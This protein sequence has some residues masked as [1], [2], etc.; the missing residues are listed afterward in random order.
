MTSGEWL[1]REALITVK[2]YPTPSAKYHETVCIAGITK[3]EGWIRLY[4]VQFRSL[5]YAQ[6]FEKYQ[7]IHFRMKK[8]ET[9]RRPESF[10][11]DVNSIRVTGHIDTTKD[12]EWNRRREWISPTLN[13]GMCEILKE[14]ESSKKSLGVFR[15]REVTDFLIVDAD[16]EWPGKKQ[17]FMNQLMLFDPPTSKLEK[18]P[19]SFK[20]KYFC[21]DE[22]CRGH[23]QSIIDWEIYELYRNVRKKTEAVEDIKQKIRDKYLAKLCASDRDTMFFVGNHSRWPASFMILGVF[24]PKKRAP[25]LFD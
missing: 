16:A 7:L 21:C 17:A 8:H 9:D 24:W 14:Q 15:P 6:Q 20:Y 1:E 12:E 13:K 4:P 3:E 23:E 10:R 11:P 19:F 5:P 25:R 22:A 2:A 18:I